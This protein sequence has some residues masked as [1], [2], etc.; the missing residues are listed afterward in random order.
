MDPH[1]YLESTNG[2]KSKRKVSNRGP[3]LHFTLGGV[4]YAEEIFC[5]PA[6]EKEKDLPFPTA[7]GSIRS[8]L[9]LHLVPF[10]YTAVL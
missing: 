7:P 1:Q 6:A 4:T 8:L 9:T 3:Q 2:L 10:H 5:N